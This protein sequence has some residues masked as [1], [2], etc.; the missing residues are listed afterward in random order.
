MISNHTPFRHPTNPEIKI[1]RYLDLPRFAS[2]LLTRSLHFA[3]TQQLG[4]PFEGL[5]IKVWRETWGHILQHRD[6]DPRLVEWRSMST[7]HLQDV[8]ALMDQT[9]MGSRT[10]HVNCWHMNEHESAAN[11]HRY[12][13]SDRIVCIQSTFRRLAEVLPRP[14]YAGEV[15][16]IDYESDPIPHLNP[17]NPVL[18]K[19]SSFSDERELRAAIFVRPHHGQSCANRNPCAERDRRISSGHAPAR[20][21]LSALSPRGSN[22]QLDWTDDGVLVPIE[23]SDLIEAIYISP[24]APGWISDVVER[25]IASQGL[26]LPM[27]RSSV[28]EMSLH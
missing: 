17:W 1:W 2:L 24:I 5:L 3:R 25:L 11:W 19:K 22:I 13:A 28:S 16:Y 9:G 10:S 4:D 21:S 12:I 27:K 18:Y 26:K 7:S 6:S 20:A 8:F 23:V 14:V 15:K